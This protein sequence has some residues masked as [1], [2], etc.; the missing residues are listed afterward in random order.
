M[1]FDNLPNYVGKIRT[2][3]INKNADFYS[4]LDLVEK[5]GNAYLGLLCCP[6]YS[7]KVDSSGWCV[8]N[9]VCLNDGEGMMAKAYSLS[10]LQ[11]AEELLTRNVFVNLFLFYGDNEAYDEDIKSHLNISKE[12]F[13]G[14]TRLSMARGRLLYQNLFSSFFERYD[15]Y[16]ITSVSMQ[17]VIYNNRLVKSKADIKLGNVD[18]ETISQIT[19]TRK[20]VLVSMYGRKLEGNK[21]LLNEKARMQIYD[22]I[23]VGTYFDRKVGNNAK[24]WGLFTLSPPHLKKFIRDENSERVTLFELGVHKDRTD[25]DKKID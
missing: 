25:F 23:I 12:S 15:S 8:Y 11:L 17:K 22:R 19:K 20:D 4:Y 5:S 18:R 21:K 10:V 3:P 6:D 1:T 14:K 9:H 7:Y 13:L 2:L 24:Y 16:S